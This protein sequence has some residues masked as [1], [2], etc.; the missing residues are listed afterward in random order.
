MA[1]Y[2]G[3]NGNSLDAN[4]AQTQ[5]T[6]ADTF[7]KSIKKKLSELTQA[8]E[9][10]K[11]RPS[12]KKTKKHFYTLIK[13]SFHEQFFALKNALLL[14]DQLCQRQVRLVNP[15]LLKQASLLAQEKYLP[16]KI[17][18][19]LQKQRAQLMDNADE[20]ILLNT[21]YRQTE[22]LEELLKKEISL[23]Q[24]QLKKTEFYKNF[25]TAHALL[26][27]E[28][29]ARS[30]L[31]LINKILHLEREK[32]IA[33]L[34]H[35]ELQSLIYQQNLSSLNKKTTNILPL[36]ANTSRV[37]EVLQLQYDHLIAPTSV[38]ILQKAFS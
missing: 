25:Q 5:R 7:D 35:K 32:A 10:L 36:S 33:F 8:L 4:I 30:A 20:A 27:K 18:V 16:Q 34:K 38:Y 31:A 19:F 1:P 15:Q 22:E 3:L 17:R 2:Q 13:S 28:K 26:V 6:I 29:E 12:F 11:K 14:L 9:S 21:M 23:V 24:T 37:P